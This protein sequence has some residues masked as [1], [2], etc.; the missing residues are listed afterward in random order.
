M[1]E[2]FSKTLSDFHAITSNLPDRT[3]ALSMK[4]MFLYMHIHLYKETR[5]DDN[6]LTH[7][8]EQK[9]TSHC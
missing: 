2:Y 3:K 7:A 8:W 5:N 1:L 4:L 9:S 6:S